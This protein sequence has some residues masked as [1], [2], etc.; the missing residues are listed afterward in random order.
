MI[1][2]RSLIQS[3]NFKAKLANTVAKTVLQYYQKCSKNKFLIY[4][5]LPSKVRAQMLE[6]TI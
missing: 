4:R 3:Y 2:H 6:G 5:L 1:S